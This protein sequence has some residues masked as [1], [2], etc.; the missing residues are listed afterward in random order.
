[1]TVIVIA[2]DF[3]DDHYSESFRWSWKSELFW[4]LPL[5]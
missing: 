3:L 1:M 4:I 2:L 5:W